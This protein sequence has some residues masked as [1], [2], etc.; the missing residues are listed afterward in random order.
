MERVEIYKTKYSSLTV[1]GL[2]GCIE[3]EKMREIY[4]GFKKLGDM[5]VNNFETVEDAFLIMKDDK[6]IENFR[7]YVFCELEGRNRKNRIDLILKYKAE[8][9]TNTREDF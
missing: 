8:I 4:R 6:E 2:A 9:K 7:T 5:C 1:E 3:V